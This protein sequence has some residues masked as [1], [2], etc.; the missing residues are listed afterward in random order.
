I[1][2]IDLRW[3]AP[4]NGDA[5]VEAASPCDAVL[6]VDECRKTGSQSEALV[7][8]FTERAPDTPI[9]RIA[10][11]DSFIPLARAATLTLPSRD[12]IVATALEMTVPKR[13]R[14]KA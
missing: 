2:I 1:R 10:A 9:R 3:L 11:Q 14:K 5:I 4:L 7:T 8:L 6:I 12:Q 13:E